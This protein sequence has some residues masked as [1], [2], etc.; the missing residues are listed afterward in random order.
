MRDASFPAGEPA[1]APAAANTLE[2]LA[3][4]IRQCRLCHQEDFLPQSTLPV[5]V[6][7]SDAR[8]MIVGQAPGRITNEQGIHFA[9][10]GGS[11]LSRWFDRAGYPSGFLRAGCY[12]SSLTHCFPGSAPSGGDRRPS[13]RELELCR[14]FLDHALRLVNPIAVLLVGKMAIDAFLGPQSLR[15]TVGNRY[16]REERVYLPLPHPSGVSRWLN[17]SE[18]QARLQSAIRHLRSLKPS[19]LAPNK[20]P[21]RSSRGNGR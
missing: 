6:A 5:A 15:D 19:V 11:L 13:Q 4:G 8:I 2:M 16:Q 18:N 10:P 9:G 1:A 20:R 7:V 17:E 21:S 3:A 12:I 14:P